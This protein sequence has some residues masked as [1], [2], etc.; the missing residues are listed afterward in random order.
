MKENIPFFF[1]VFLFIVF[2]LL[3]S[4]DQIIKSI[5][6]AKKNAKKSADEKAQRFRDETGRQ[7][8]QYHFSGKTATEQQQPRSVREDKSEGPEEI[9]TMTATGETIIDQRKGRDNRKIYD[10]DD[11]EYVEFSEE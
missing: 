2:L 8:R 5:K 1:F 11:G 10:S 7:Q 4:G 3:L 6:K 9:R